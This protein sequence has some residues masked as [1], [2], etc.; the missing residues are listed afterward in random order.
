[1]EKNILNF[2][3][4]IFN[5]QLNNLLQSIA[6]NRLTSNI[7]VITILNK[8]IYY[9]KTLMED[10]IMKDSFDFEDIKTSIQDGFQ[11]AAKYSDNFMQSSRIKVI[12]N[13]KKG[14][15]GEVYKEIGE[16]QY[17]TQ[18]SN[19]NFDKLYKKADKIENEIYELEKELKKYSKS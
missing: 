4:L 19:F 5:F 12:I 6:Q 8:R 14:E 15:L 11:K 3:L 2:T 13:R 1:M 16:K 7:H 17:H 18:K 10:F 9:T